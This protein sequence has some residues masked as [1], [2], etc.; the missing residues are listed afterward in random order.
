ME[1]PIGATQVGV[2]VV[3]GHGSVQD[4]EPQ[5]RQRVAELGGNHGLVDH[6]TTRFDM[7]TSWVNEYYP[8]GYRMSA[9]C[10]RM[11]PRIDEYATLEISGRA[12]LIGAAQ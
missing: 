7:Q 6:V 8:C 10:S 5:F 4:L 11:V 1:L 3:R 9:T 2:V 12:F